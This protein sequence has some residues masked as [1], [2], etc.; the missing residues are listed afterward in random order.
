MADKRSIASPD[1]P[2]A[3]GPYSQAIRVDSMV[4]ISGQIPLGPETMELVGDD[5]GEQTHQVFKN[6]QAVAEASGGDLNDIVKLTIYMTDLSA[7][8][9]INEIM[10]SYFSKPS[11]ARATIE[12][13]SLP[14]SASVEIDAI[15]A[16][17][18]K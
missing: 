16:A 9:V 1:A 5:L 15:L 12:V 13:S 7:F 6:L 10:A 14:K 4:F 17:G 8:S 2:R 11:P 18:L 3:I